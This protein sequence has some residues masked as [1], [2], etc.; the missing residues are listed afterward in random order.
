MRLG[1]RDF[2]P[3]NASTA[4]VAK[5]G[6]AAPVLLDAIATERCAA[7]CAT[8][9]RRTSPTRRGPSP[10]GHA[11]PV[12]LD[13]IATE[14][15]RRGLRDFNQQDLVN[16]AWAFATAGHAAPA[17][18]DAI[19][20]EAVRGGLRD[21][22][23]QELANTAWAFATAGHVAPALLDAIATAAVLLGLRDFTAEPRRQGVASQGRPR[24]ADTARR[25]RRAVRGGLRESPQGLANTA[26]L[27]KAGRAAPVLLDAIATEAVRGGLRD[28]AAGAREHGALYVAATLAGCSTDAR[29][30]CAA[31]RDTPQGLAN[32]R[33]RSP[34]PRCR[35]CST[36][37]SEVHGLRDF[38]PQALRTWRGRRRRPPR[39]WQLRQ[40][41]IC[42][43][44]VCGGGRFRA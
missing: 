17:L 4:C 25:D 31:L 20:T 36:R 14:A 5:A 39:A 2:T 44:A 41:R 40:R 10:A 18:L 21:F 13:A 15:V 6:H 38:N 35:C 26:G 1:L 22:K 23:P 42:A 11:A 19:A 7:A 3:Q 37:R 29:R 34:R 43:G 27:A 24:R 32:T 16:T 9:R 33:G 28:F 12:L 8:S 30:R